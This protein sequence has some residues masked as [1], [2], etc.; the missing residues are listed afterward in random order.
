MRLPLSLN[1]IRQLRGDSM[2]SMK[3]LY[4]EIDEKEL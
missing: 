4:Y 2:N 1:I 3:E